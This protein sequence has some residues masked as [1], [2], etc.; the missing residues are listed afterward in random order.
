MQSLKKVFNSPS[1]FALVIVAII[2]LIGVYIQ[3]KFNKDVASLSINA[4]ST[5]E[6]KL[7][8]AAMLQPTSIPPTSTSTPLPPRLIFK[9]TFDDIN[10]PAGWS[11]GDGTEKEFI[12][13]RYI[14]DGKY[15]RKMTSTDITNGTFGSVVIPAVSE[16][17]FCLFFDVLS[18]NASQG[19][20]IVVIFRAFKYSSDDADNSS[21]YIYFKEDGTASIF[22]DP[23]GA[24][25][26]SLIGTIDNSIKWNDNTSHTIKISVQDELLEVYNGENNQ[27]LYQMILNSEGTLSEEGGLRIGTGVN[28]PGQNIDMA[29]D[30]IAVYD[31]CP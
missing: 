8:Q 18:L 2:T 3:S 10:N 29:F 30:N 11:V 22:S 17:N 23:Q 24:N 13:S 20:S 28:K 27:S 15:F 5:A 16:K 12:Y 6:A 25:N 9:E 26:S 19:T 4:T 7:T 21:Y 1:S 14:S 31:R